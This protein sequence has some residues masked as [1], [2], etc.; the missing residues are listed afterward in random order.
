MDDSSYSMASVDPNPTF[1]QFDD[2]GYS[3]DYSA[4]VSTYSQLGTEI[5][6]AIAGIAGQQQQTP[7]YSQN[8]PPM[9][10]PKTKSNAA[11]ILVA[12]VGIG[13]A[14]VLISGMKPN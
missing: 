4:A 9:T 1:D 12:V 11:M 8:Y 6:S 7:V 5:A 13:V 2:G 14:Y 10:P 3:S